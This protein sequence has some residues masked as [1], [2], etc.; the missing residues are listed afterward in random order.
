[1][2]VY[3]C[4]SFLVSRLSRF[5]HLRVELYHSDSLIHN[6]K[7]GGEE[8][9]EEEENVDDIPNRPKVTPLREKEGKRE[10]ERQYS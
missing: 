1:M 10:E 4:L 3:A 9:E 2:L 5:S 8:H 7:D 6:A